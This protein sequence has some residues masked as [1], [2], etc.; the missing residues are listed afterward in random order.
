MNRILIIFL[1]IGFYSCGENQKSEKKTETDLVEKGVSEL[2]DFD[3][4]QDFEQNKA[5]FGTDTF[6]LFGH[7]S[8]GGELIVFH[9][10]KFDYIVY[11]FWIYGEL[12]KLNYTYWTEKNGETSFKFIKKLEY[13]YDKPFYQGD[14]E[15][16][17]TIN[18]L[19]YSNS[20][21][22]LFD[23]NKAEITESELIEKSKLELESFFT[24]VTKGIEII[25]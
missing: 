16:D 14:F 20:K 6:D 5:E 3:L 21:I 4:L 23:I 13:S 25:K 19:S 15:M 17:S 24:D 2:K 22:K 10:K 7:S 8:E 9:D 18:Y 12:G 1:I 11:D